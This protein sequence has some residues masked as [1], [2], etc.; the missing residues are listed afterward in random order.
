MA[1]NDPAEHGGGGSLSQKLQRANRFARIAYDADEA[2]KILLAI[3]QLGNIQFPLI[4]SV[5]GYLEVG[6]IAG[7]I[8]VYSRGFVQS[9]TDGKATPYFT[10]K[11]FREGAPAG[12][13]ALHEVVLKQRNKVVAHA[14]W[15]QHNTEV[16]SQP[17]YVRS[18]SIPD[19]WDVIALG[20]FLDLTDH[21][22]RVAEMQ[23]YLLTLPDAEQP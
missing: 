19:Y 8:T 10:F 12:A 17:G 7:A 2:H 9:K 11:A 6:A 16:L 15:E 1:G 21:V 3:Q 18:S 4:T 14:D 22:A 5:S 13:E 20:N 23:A